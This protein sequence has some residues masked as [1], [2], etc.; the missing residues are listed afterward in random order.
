MGAAGEGLDLQHVRYQHPVDDVGRPHRHREQ[1]ADARL[2]PVIG[3]RPE[4]PPEV[5]RIE[6]GA[7]VQHEREGIVA[8][9]DYRIARQRRRAVGG[10]DHGRLTLPVDV[11]V[12]HGMGSQGGPGQ[13]HQPREGLVELRHPI[14]LAGPAA[15]F[16]DLSQGQ[17]GGGETGGPGGR[18]PV[19]ELADAVPEPGQLRPRRAEPALLS[20]QGVV[21]AEDEG[22]VAKARRHRLLPGPERAG[23]GVRHGKQRGQYRSGRRAGHSYEFDAMALRDI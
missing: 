23:R 5:G 12:E 15:L 11:E 9:A 22:A 17:G 14:E 21:P 6:G 19:V 8:Q 16:R 10:A 7:A 1:R 3:E 4:Q 18:V 13:A 20:P 2:A